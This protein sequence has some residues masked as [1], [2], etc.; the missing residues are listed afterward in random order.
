ME[1]PDTNSL[2]KTLSQPLFQSR[3]WMKLIGIMMIIYGTLVA[4]TV[5]GLIFAWL[6]IWLGILLFQAASSAE[7]AHITGNA[8]EML[9]TQKRLKTYFTIMGIITLISLLF[10][11]LGFF[12]GMGGFVMHGG[13]HM[14]GWMYGGM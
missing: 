5:I 11:L 14:G 3:G 1:H 9:V 13:G 7:D 6:P 2:V 12:L 10:G 8:D 4:L